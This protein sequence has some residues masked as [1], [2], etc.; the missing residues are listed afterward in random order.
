MGLAW[1]GRFR[2]ARGLSDG[3]KQTNKT[4]RRKSKVGPDTHSPTMI[5][6]NRQ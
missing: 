1:P 6:E 3:T 4:K 2:L 5:R